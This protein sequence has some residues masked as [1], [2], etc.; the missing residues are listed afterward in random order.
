MNL[1][2]MTSIYAGTLL[3]LVWQVAAIDNGLGRTPHMGWNSWN[4]FSCNISEDLIKSTV[5]TIVNDGLKEAG[6]KYVCLDDCWQG[7]RDANGTIHSDPKKFPSGIKALADYVHSYGLLFGIYSDAGEMTCAGY[8]GSRFFEEQD[9]QTYAE[10]GVDLLKYDN[11]YAP[12][13]DW[14]IDRYQAMSDAL[15]KYAP[16]ERPIY[17]ATCDWGVQDP[18]N[19]ARPMANSWRVDNDIADSWNDLLR[20]LDNS[21]NLARFA[22]PGGWNDPDMLEVGNGGMTYLEYESHFA[23]WCLMKAPLIIG[24]DLTPEGVPNTTGWTNHTQWV[25]LNEELIAVNQDPLG[26]AGDLVWQEGPNEVWAGPLKNGSRA[27]VLFNRHV[28]S[29]QYPLQNITVTWEMIGYPMDTKAYV[30][31]LYHKKDLGIFQGSFTGLAD[32]HGCVAIKVTPVDLDSHPEYEDWR[33]W[34][35]ATADS[36]NTMSPLFWIIV[37]VA[38]VVFFLFGF[39]ISGLYYRRRKGEPL[40]DENYEN[41]Q[42][43][44]QV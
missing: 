39:L 43:R 23:L 21:V 17:Y 2:K 38:A 22:G 1:L 16:P 42:G 9:A 4:H 37:P 31:D 24:C 34:Q 33:P 32:I 3:L 6:Y 13:S 25:L 36:S 27:V 40:L 11:C 26:V 12:S 5:R 15:I 19:W 18:W 41:V 44:G 20:C 29:S 28:I 30:R 14:V 35:K 8:P 10:W 7:Y